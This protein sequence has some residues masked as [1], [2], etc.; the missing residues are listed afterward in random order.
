MQ[1]TKDA[2]ITALIARKRFL[3]R[4]LKEA[5]DAYTD[6]AAHIY[7]LDH[8]LQTLQSYL[9]L[10]ENPATKEAQPEEVDGDRPR[11]RLTP[12]SLSTHNEADGKSSATRPAPSSQ[13]QK[14]GSRSLTMGG[15]ARSSY[16]SPWPTPGTRRGEGGGKRAEVLD[17]IRRHP[18]G[19]TAGQITEALNVTDKSGK[20]SV[21]NCALRIK[22]RQRYHSGAEA[23]AIYRSFCSRN[24]ESPRLISGAFSAKARLVCV[25]KALAGAFVY[26]AFPMS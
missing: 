22:E 21:A 6:A 19:L 4:Q 26:R 16:H 8:E 5:Q 20:Q 2:L 7:E 17:L 25:R 10:L 18:E 3:D 1:T 11:R 12:P 14:A 13:K 15:E 9:S 23:R 24:E